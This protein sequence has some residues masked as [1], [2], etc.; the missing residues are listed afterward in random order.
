MGAKKKFRIEKSAGGLVTR[1]KGAVTQI[2]MVEVKNLLGEIR[3]TFPKGHLEKGE[4]NEEAALREV[5]EE[6]G[7]RCVILGASRTGKSKAFEEVA[8]WFRR[9]PQLIRKEVIWYLMDPVR[10][11]G[12]SDPDEIRKVKWMDLKEAEKKADYPSDVKL[13]KKLTAKL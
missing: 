12:E 13:L 1:L 8:Y 6:T 3:W 10:Q 11:T 7:W 4:S 5:E 2:L 9:G